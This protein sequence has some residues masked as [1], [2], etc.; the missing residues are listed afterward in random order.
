H[1][2]SPPA[3]ARRRIAAPVTD[4]LELARKYRLPDRVRDV[5]AQHHGTR[6]VGA[7][8]QRAV[9]QNDG[10]TIDQASFRYPGPRPQS[11]EAAIIMLADGVEATLRAVH[12]HTA[13][14]I[15]RTIR[16]VVDERLTEGQLDE[17]DLTFRDLER[18][19]Q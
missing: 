6:F 10:T 7:F 13:E 8:Y 5:I 14:G 3:P 18:I 16:K 9:A 15:E 19:R 2:P 17:C 11:R 12:D 4:G 1:A